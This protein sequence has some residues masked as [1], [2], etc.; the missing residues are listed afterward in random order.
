ME[1][2]HLIVLFYDFR[3]V[4]RTVAASNPSACALIVIAPG[5]V[6]RMTAAGHEWV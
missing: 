3:P 2:R 4:M 5:W 6:A 1:M